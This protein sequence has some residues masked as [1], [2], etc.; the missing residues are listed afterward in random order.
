MAY[1]VILLSCLY[2]YIY[3][4]Y[5]RFC[6]YIG[7][8]Q[9]FE[10]LRFLRKL[11]DF[12]TFFFDRCYIEGVRALARAQ[13]YIVYKVLSIYRVLPGFREF[14]VFEKSKRFFYIFLDEC[15]IEGVRALARAQMYIVAYIAARIYRGW[16]ESQECAIFKLQ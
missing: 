7:S 2:I 13:I 8:C 5:T 11:S 9:V 16:H 1:F 12:S 3:V 4:Q 6:L 15:Y 14:A 10:N